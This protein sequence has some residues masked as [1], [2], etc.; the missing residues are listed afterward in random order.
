MTTQA[1]HFLIAEQPG[2]VNRRI[3]EFLQADG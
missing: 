2:Q 1:G 3:V